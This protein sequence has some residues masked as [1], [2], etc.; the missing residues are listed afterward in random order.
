MVSLTHIA[1]RT[2]RTLFAAIAD[3]MPAPSIAIPAS[4]SPLGHASR[5]RTGDIRIVYRVG[6]VCSHVEHRQT[7]AAQMSHERAFD[8]QARV[9]AADDHAPD[10]AR[11]RQITWERFVR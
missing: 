6:R 11:G 8:R 10:V 5:D 2:P 3:P 9:I 1:A 4:D 7:A